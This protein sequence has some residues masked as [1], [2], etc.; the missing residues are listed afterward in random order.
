VNM[1]GHPVTNAKEKKHQMTHPISITSDRS[2]EISIVI[3]RCLIYRAL[4]PL[5]LLL[6]WRRRLCLGH[7]R[8]C[9]VI[10]HLGIALRRGL[11]GGLVNRCGRLLRLYILR[12]LG[13]DWWRHDRRIG[14]VV[15]SLMWVV[16]RR[17]TQGSLLQIGIVVCVLLLRHLLHWWSSGSRLVNS[18]TC[19]TRASHH[20]RIGILLSP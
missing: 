2:S 16:L 5:E 13:L 20:C 14:I 3:T 18:G 7:W 19:N 17:G 12:V 11:V 9:G 8:C 1:F 15:G 6:L 10:R 4:W